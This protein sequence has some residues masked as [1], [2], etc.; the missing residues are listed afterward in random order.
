MNIDDASSLTIP[1]LHEDAAIVVV[2][3]PAGLLTVPGIGA[4]NQDCLISRM[5]Q[6]LG[7]GELRIVHRLDQHTSGVLVLARDAESHRRLSR[8]FEERRVSKRYVAIVA[9]VV[10]DDE[11]TI[12]LPL[13]KDMT[14]KSRHIV[15]HEHGKPALTTWRVLERRERITRLA[16]VPITGRSHQLRVHLSAIDHPILGD[17]LYAPPEVVAQA[18]RLML[19]A[20]ELAFA[21]PT[22]GEAMTFASPPPF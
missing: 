12:D 2:S 13:R 14:R 11:G 15:D 5:R 20:E 17:D 16:L 6:Q 21:H 8:A 10:D 4:A 9:G 19:H 3:K 1:V 22:T 7:D 18:P